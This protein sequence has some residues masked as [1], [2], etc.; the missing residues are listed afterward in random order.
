MGPR[1][2][3]GELQLGMMNEVADEI[4]GTALDPVVLTFTDSDSNSD[5]SDAPQF[6]PSPVKT[7]PPP[8]TVTAPDT[9]APL[10]VV[11]GNADS[12]PLAG[13][14]SSSLSPMPSLSNVKRIRSLSPDRAPLQPVKRAKN[15]ARKSTQHISTSK[16]HIL[17]PSFS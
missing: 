6:I 15:T 16:E 1:P 13:E 17:I 9:Q 5:S 3:G 2:S 8:P 11:V 10:P 12:D 4:G 14:A 7:E